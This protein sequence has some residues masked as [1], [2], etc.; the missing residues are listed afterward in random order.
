MSHNPANIEEFI[1]HMMV[2]CEPRKVI[3]ISKYLND[4]NYKAKSICDVLRSLHRM[5][6][7]SKDARKHW[8]NIRDKAKEIRLRNTFRYS[9]PRYY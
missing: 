8:E 6:R 5:C 1:R 4:P 9:S 2:P 3:Q 7:V